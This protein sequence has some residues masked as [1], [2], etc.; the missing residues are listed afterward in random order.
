MNLE[1][2]NWTL[3]SGRDWHVAWFQESLRI[4]DWFT[5]QDDADSDDWDRRKSNS[6]T[7]KTGTNLCHYARCSI[8]WGPG[9]IL[10]QLLM[11]SLVLG[12]VVFAP[13][14]TLGVLGYIGMWV[15]GAF[16][17]AAFFGLYK[18]A[19]WFDDTRAG[20]RFGDWLGKFLATPVRDL[21][22]ATSEKLSFRNTEGVS[23][24]SIVW[25]FVVTL[26]HQVCPLIKIEDTE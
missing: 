8:L 6:A 17:A 3:K 18:F 2:A 10:L 5:G 22:H 21:A 20:R 23:L 16:V 13:L 25:A 26:K 7:F 14:K 1:R 15:I 19:A 12:A 11:V 9:I 4:I 24:W